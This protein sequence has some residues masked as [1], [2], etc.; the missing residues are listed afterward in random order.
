MARVVVVG[1]LNVDLHLLLRRHILP[2]E[3]LIAS[4]GTFSPGGK[5]ANQACA[6][7]LAGAD[8]TMCGA[9]GD[10][11][12]APVAT[13][14]LAEAGVD[15]THVRRL[16]GATGLAVVSVDTEGENTVVVVPGA[17]AAVTPELVRGWEPVIG[18]ADVVVLQGEIPATSDLEVVGCGPRRLVVNLAPVIDVD[19]QLLLVADP[20]VVNEHEGAAA[21][22]QLGG[23][24]VTEPADVVAGLRAAGVASVVMTLGGGRGAGRLVGRHR[25]GSVAPGAPRRHRRGRRRLLRRARRAGRRRGFPRGCRGLRSAFRGVHG[26]V[27]GSPGLLPRPRNGPPRLT[28]RAI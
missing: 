11:S 8:V 20:L 15:L 17:N 9:V 23:P 14:L 25:V 10:D 7:A 12:S 2:G 5:G 22:S 3:T 21:L 19:P 27:R 1:S 16:S 28:H 13:T 18:A 6:A 24:D 26:P 4:G